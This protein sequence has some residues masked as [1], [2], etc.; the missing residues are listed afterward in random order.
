VALDCKPWSEPA[1]DSRQV[2]LPAAAVAVPLTE[3]PDGMLELVGS[4]SHFVCTIDAPASWLDVT[5]ICEARIGGIDVPISV[6]RLADVQL[7]K[8]TSDGR[9]AGVLFRIGGVAFENVR[10]KAW[11]TTVDHSECVIGARVWNSD[12]PLGERAIREPVDLYVRPGQVRS[13]TSGAA[14][15]AA[16]LTTIFPRNPLPRGRVGLTQLQ[17]TRLDAGGAT[18]ELQEWNAAGLVAVR[19]VWAHRGAGDP[20]LLVDTTWI[21]PLWSAAE[22]F[23]RLSLSAGAAANN[24]VNAQAVDD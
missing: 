1:E 3:A 16:G 14:G 24:L 20:S 10:V 21:P 12:S 15:I 8:V 4:W 18:L 19:G 22:N 11:R 23:W 17:W 6:V 5:F 7:P 9:V 2:A 13:F